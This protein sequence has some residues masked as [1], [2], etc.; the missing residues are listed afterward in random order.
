MTGKPELP[1][2]PDCPAGQSGKV[3]P[4]KQSTC[5]Q[6]PQAAST[7]DHGGPRRT[8]MDRRLLAWAYA[9]RRPGSEAAASLA[10]HRRAALA[11]S[12]AVGGAPAAWP[13]RRGAA[14]RRRAGAG[15]AR[16]RP[17]ADLSR[18]AL[19][20]V[21][22]GDTRLAAALGAGVHLRAGRW[23][24]VLRRRHLLITSSAHGRA[25]LLRAHRAGAGLA[26]LSPAF[27]TPEPPGV[28]ALGPARWTRLARAAR[29][30]VAAL[31][32]VDGAAVRRLPRQICRARGSDRRPRLTAMCLF[33]H[34][35]SRLP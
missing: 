15:S 1:P 14:P 30:P 21:V 25:D 5:P 32:G 31:G 3:H 35:V 2:S 6:D 18:A 9:S 24:C 22:A 33:D 13:R 29:L 7:T 26:F 11:R 16:A 34:S 4:S 20:L 10:V 17:G 12:P 28:T 23:P 19:A 8:T 27:P